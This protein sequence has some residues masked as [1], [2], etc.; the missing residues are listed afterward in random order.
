MQEVEVVFHMNSM[1]YLEFFFRFK[2]FPDGLALYR[3]RKGAYDIDI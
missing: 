2:G 3:W 1:L